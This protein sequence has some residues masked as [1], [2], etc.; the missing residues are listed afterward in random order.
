MFRNNTTFVIGAGASAEFGLP[1]GSELARRISRSAILKDLSSPRRV[2]GDDT[3]YYNITRMWPNSVER[4]K[5]LKAARDIHE[6]IHTAVSIDA[7]IHRFPSDPYIS[8]IGKMLIA[9]EIAKAERDS[10]M[11]PDNWNRLAEDARMKLLN[12]HQAELINPDDTWIGSF[13]RIL[14]DGVSDPTKLGENIIIICFNYDRCIEY[15]LR[16][17]IA[18]AYRIPLGDAHE[19]VMKM[20]I[21]H[22]YGTLGGLTLNDSG[23]GDGLL[24]FGA[25]MDQ[26]IRLEEIAKNIRTYTEQTHDI[27]R[28]MKIHNA[29]G[30][31]NVLVFLGFGFNNQNLDLLRVKAFPEDYNLNARNVYTTGMGIERQV[32]NTLKRRIAN[33]FENYVA[34]GSLWPDR[35]YIEHNETCAKLFGIHNM[36]LSHFTERYADHDGGILRLIRSS[37]EEN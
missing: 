29:I 16:R 37:A 13:F 36:N 12:Q 7:F 3:F 24:S 35:I 2:I 15:Y 9:L 31:S 25:K 10:S 19:I 34:E 14:C 27:N 32:S 26:N 23:Y 20:N 5:P 8:Q 6:G 22:P 28:T 18:A 33:I 21:I 11:W 4:A 17:Q 30:N 1:V